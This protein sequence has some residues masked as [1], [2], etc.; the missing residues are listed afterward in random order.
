MEGEV[1]T[2]ILTRRKKRPVALF[3]GLGLVMA[4]LMPG[5]PA[6]VAQNAPPPACPAVLPVNALQPGM[7]GVG[8]T[9]SQGLNP[10]PFDVEILGVLDDGIAPGKDMII[11]EVDSPAIEIARGIWSGMSGSPVYIDGKLVGAIAY[12]FSLGPSKIGGVTPAEEMMRVLDYVGGGGDDESVRTTALPQTVE[13]TK[14]QKRRIARRSE[15]VTAA[16]VGDF[17]R[18]K[19]PF[20]VSGGASGSRIKMLRKAAKRENLSIIP[21]A[22]SAATT[23]PPA[24][25]SIDPGDSF[26]AALSYGDVTNAAVGTATAVCNGKVLAFGH[27]FLFEGKTTMGASPASTITIIDDPTLTPF[28]MANVLGPAGEVEQDR[29]AAIRADLSELP[30]FIPI[31]STV[32][33]TNTNR[34][35]DGKTDGVLSEAMPF[36]TF[37]H[38]LF[39]IDA[40]YDEIGEG[41]SELTWTVTGTTEAG[42]QWTLTRSNM[43][44]SDFDIAI[45]SLFELEEHMYALANNEFEDVQF[46]GVD[47][48]ATVH[49]EVRQYTIS[50]VNAARNRGRFVESNKLK[51]RRGDTVRLRVVLEPF[52]QTENKVVN[53]KVKVPKKAK[54]K[55]N[56]FV[57]GAE[58]S[59]GIFCFFDS[60]CSDQYG[61]K[62]ESLNDLIKALEKTPKNNEVRAVI[63]RKRCCKVASAD[64][65]LLDKVV[66]GR[67]RIKLTVLK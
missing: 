38:M 18:L 22:S 53:L 35:R 20:A 52:D 29:Q 2:K 40:T 50:D 63:Y 9:V 56:L 10:D 41:S 61:N 58:F 26:A 34:T 47:I 49:E 28:K 64:S 30:R 60:D 14:N 42:Q 54:R 8:Y 44:V 6:A 32:S 37:L 55:T 48:D 4:G 39:N 13:L 67:K 62:I 27:P 3:A 21:Y 36:L 57:R 59:G 19:L 65:E 24:D 5:S 15:S 45:E 43:F 33:A 17:E 1:K 31:T 51:V 25:A 12:G 66:L 7:T 46:T 16:Q 11:V 23:A